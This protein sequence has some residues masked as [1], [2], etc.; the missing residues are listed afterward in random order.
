MSAFGADSLLVS[1]RFASLRPYAFALFFPASITYSGG[2]RVPQHELLACAQC[3]CFAFSC[4]E[5]FAIR[6]NVPKNKRRGDLQVADLL[7]ILISSLMQV[8]EAR[9]RVSI[10]ATSAMSNPESGDSPYR[11]PTRAVDVA[12]SIAGG[13]TEDVE[14]TLYLSTLAETHAGAET[15]EEALNRDRDFLPARTRETDQTLLVRRRAIRTVTI[16]GDEGERASARGESCVGRLG[17]FG[18]RRWRDYRRHPCYRAPS[19]KGLAFRT[20]L[21]SAR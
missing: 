8:P 17:A 15:M 2:E 4:F 14:V 20:T 12:L 13:R 16:G 3:G 11:A 9:Y 5:D 7:G 10:G 19:G 1:L 18:A 6:A 21:M